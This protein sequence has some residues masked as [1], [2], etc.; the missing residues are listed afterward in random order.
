ML[1]SA[2]MERVL[3]NLDRRLRSVEQILPTLSTKSDLDTLK[4]HADMR[5]EDLRDDISKV[6][7]GVASMAST[8]RANQQ[9][10]EAV[11]RRLDQHQ[12]ALKALVRKHG[13]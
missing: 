11:V 10:L 13:I 3:D 1:S 7:E 8:V 9:T 2:D 6:A 5:F 4:R 12:D